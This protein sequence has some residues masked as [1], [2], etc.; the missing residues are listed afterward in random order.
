MIE[1]SNQSTV[2][3]EIDTVISEAKKVIG[4][5]Y[6]WAGTTPAGFDCSGFVYYAFKQAGYD[7]S[8]HSAATYYSLGEKHFFTPKRVIWSFLQQDLTNPTSIIWEYT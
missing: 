2:V 7:I 5:P 1:P 8:R 4:T 6:L 3:P